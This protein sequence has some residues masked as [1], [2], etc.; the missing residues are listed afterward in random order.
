MFDPFNFEGF[1]G[2]KWP[3]NGIFFRKSLLIGP[4]FRV[5]T[6]SR[7]VAK[8]GANR[9]LG[10]C[11]KVISFCGQKTR[12]R[13][14][15]PSLRLPIAP[16]GV[17]PMNVWSIH[18]SSYLAFSLP[19]D[20]LNKRYLPCTFYVNQRRVHPR[21]PVIMPPPRMGSGALSGDRRPSSVR[22]S[23]CLSDVAYIGSNSKTKR[24][25]K[26][27]LST[28]VPQITCDS[29]TD[30]KV[31]RSKVKVGRGHIVAAT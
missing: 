21:A 8:F 31:K 2:Y 10:S 12:L 20:L 23:V 3:L 7:V 15:R 17:G 4:T 26:T 19:A 22:P 5:D 6:D 27:K 16:T 13:G 18:L 30:F 25:R 29:H 1:F 9:P 28:G 11:R 14:S 24:P